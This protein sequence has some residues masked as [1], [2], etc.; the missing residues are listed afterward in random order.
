MKFFIFF[1]LT[2]MIIHA[3]ELKPWTKK[4]EQLSEEEKY[5]IIEKGTE[6][7]FIGKYTN[8]KSEG[9]YVCKVCGTPLYKSSD[10][11]ESN[12]GWPSF[13]D[14]IKG[15]VKRVPDADSRRIEIVCATCGAHLGHIF[16]GEGFTPKDTRH[17]V[18][19]IS[20]ELVK[21]EHNAKDS[22]SYAYFAGGCFWGVEYYLEKLKGVREVISGFMGG[23][24]KNPTYHDVVYSNTGHLEAVEVVY[25]RSE[26]SYEELA[27]VFFEIHDPTQANGQGPDIGEQYL[28][29]VFVSSEEEKK[30]ILGLISKLETNG[31]KIATKIFDKEEFYKAEEYHQNY[32]E[33][34]GSI[35]YCHGYTK[36]F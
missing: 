32:Y 24:T 14:E 11:F 3:I 2:I 31:Y 27:K 17:C 23:H 21:K 36:R 30:I 1:I 28:S 34:K 6:R 26:I 19:S 20:L 25:D 29:G 9:T 18:N 16:Q 4:I 7:P 8:E 22:L 35:P 12:C 15:A 10:K 33:K 13:D 5:V